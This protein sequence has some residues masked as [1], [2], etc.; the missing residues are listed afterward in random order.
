MLTI[1]ISTLRGTNMTFDNVSPEITVY[2]IKELV[3][4]AQ[5]GFVHPNIQRIIHQG[6]QWEDHRTLVSYSLESPILAHLVLR[7]VGCHSPFPP[8]RTSFPQ[9][10]ITRNV[11]YNGKNWWDI[12]VLSLDELV[13]KSSNRNLGWYPQGIHGH[14]ASPLLY[15][16]VLTEIRDTDRSLEE[17]CHEILLKNGYSK[18]MDGWYDL[19]DLQDEQLND[20]QALEKKRKCIVEWSTPTTLPPC[21]IND[22]ESKYDVVTLVQQMMKRMEM[23]EKKI[24]TLEVQV[25]YPVQQKSSL[26]HLVPFQEI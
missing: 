13:N 11:L 8:I 3:C 9:H 2:Q 17:V 6:R 1:I 14:P 10:E 15:H 19:Q 26:V 20:H 21:Q 7:Q 25:Q 16:A 22:H 24:H 23:L 12:P 18:R 5:F 4:A